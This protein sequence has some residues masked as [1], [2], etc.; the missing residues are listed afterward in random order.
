LDVH[1]PLY[2]RYSRPLSFPRGEGVWERFSV[3]SLNC[4][5]E[6]YPNAGTGTRW[7]AIDPGMLPRRDRTAMH[8]SPRHDRRCL[9][10]SPESQ[11]A[12][13]AANRYRV[14]A[15]GSVTVRAP[16]GVEAPEGQKPETPTAACSSTCTIRGGTERI[17]FCQGAHGAL[18]NRPVGIQA[19][20]RGSVAQGLTTPPSFAIGLRFT[21]AAT[22]LH[23]T[24]CFTGLPVALTMLVKAVQRL[25]VKQH[26][27]GS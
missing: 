6:T 5:D 24:P 3:V 9:P 13:C 16:S 19:V 4:R 8:W 25:P 20:V 21:V 17:S 18:E 11:G 27:H 14:W 2:F 10:P 26:H 12:T 23:H 15:L 22:M 1:E 7:H